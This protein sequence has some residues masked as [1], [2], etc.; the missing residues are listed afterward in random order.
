MSDRSVKTKREK[1]RLKKVAVTVILLAAVLLLAGLALAGWLLWSRTPPAVPESAPVEAPSPTPEPTPEPRPL[2]GYFVCEDGLFYPERTLTLGEL[3][4]ALAR[5]AGRGEDLPGDAAEELTESTFRAAL[6]SVFDA[7]AVDAAMGSTARR[8]GPA[9]TRA[10][11]AVILNAL[12][13]PERSGE[14]GVFPDV[15]DGYWAAEDI[16]LAAV[17]GRVWPDGRAL[18]APGFVWVDGWLYYADGDGHFL[19][20]GRLGSLSFT[21]TGRY[22][23]GSYELDGYVAAAIAASTDDSMTRE[24][25]LR[26]MY[27]YVRDSFTYLRRHYY[28]LGDTGWALEEATTMYSTGKGNCYCYASA[29]WAAARAL[30][31]DAKIVSGTYGKEKAPHGWVEIY[32]GEAGRLTYD[33]EIE[34]VQRRDGNEKCDMFALDEQARR[35]HGYIELTSSDNLA[36]RE[37]ND[38]LLPG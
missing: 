3:S 20:N 38:G 35:G 31:Y 19:K 36:P 16:A 23:S 28:R 14:G 7:D 11:A 2:G 17:S 33:V 29:F 9:V 22:T 21:S 15:E 24:E 30:G 6:A 10:E 1:K 32:Q 27:L 4:A 12:L 25:R 34:M 8:G 18:P 5:A 13:D 26:A 37:T